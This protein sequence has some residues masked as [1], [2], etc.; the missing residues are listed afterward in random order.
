MNTKPEILVFI[1][2]FWPG[3]LA[4]GPVQSILSMVDYLRNDI[5]F[6]IVTT[7]CDLNSK[8]PYPGIPV[9]QWIASPLG[10]EVM[11]LS[12]GEINSTQI[13]TILQNTS[14][15]AVYI[16][17]FFSKFFSIVPLQILNADF[18]N[19][20]VILA[21]RGMLGGGALAIKKFKKQLFILYAKIIKLHNHVLWHATSDQEE[22]EILSVFKN[23][24]RLVKISNLPKKLTAPTIRKKESGT[25]L[26]CFISRISEKKNLIFALQTLAQIKTVNVIFNIYGPQE[27]PLYWQKCLDIMNTLPANIKASYKGVIEP[28][29][30]EKTLATEHMLFLPTYNENFGH[31]I[32]ESLM[33][34]C[35][36]IISDQTPWNDL[37]KQNAG[38]ALSL[39]NPQKFI[40]TIIHCA[41]LNQQEYS[42]KSAAAINYIREKINLNLIINQYKELF[43]ERLKN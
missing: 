14:F 33:C 22:K 30:L 38:Y 34:G 19:K 12:S 17:S 40:E 29:H 9:N 13:K 41:N 21:P 6:K 8:T 37:E 4:G 24:R 1:D 31:S 11:Y 27:D 39:T 25:I 18:K 28:Q 23:T 36:A 15:E 20:P 43:N 2:W 5:K 42:E 32:V 26:L 35:P 7:N 10:C 16:N 3:Y